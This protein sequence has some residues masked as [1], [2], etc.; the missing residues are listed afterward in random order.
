MQ[1]IHTRRK[2]SRH[3]KWRA[4]TLL[5]AV[6]AIISVVGVRALLD[7]ST[8]SAAPQI[9]GSSGRHH[10]AITR[11]EIPGSPSGELQGGVG[12]GI[13]AADG[14]VPDGVTVFDNGYPAISNLDPSLLGA[15]RA[16][17]TDAGLDG[18]E[19][20]VN[21]GWRSVAYQR[22]L[23]DKAVDKYGSRTQASRWVA[24]PSTSPHVSGEAV[25]VGGDDA[26]TWLSMHGSE[27][28]LCQIYGNVPWHYELR[29]DAM[30]DGCPAMYSD[31]TQ[32]PRM[33]R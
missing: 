29:F 14:L 13:D 25:D 18:V 10:S 30:D 22:E 21:S 15:L 2:T 8:T 28:G 23:L 9:D 26:A 32:D 16:A 11:G 4:S 17:A 33:Q 31:P 7:P 3:R 20:H 5:I 27:Y 19:I 1:D 24:T 6:G 12:I